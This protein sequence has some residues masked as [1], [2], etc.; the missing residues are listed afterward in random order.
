MRAAIHILVIVS[1]AALF[2]AALSLFV[3]FLPGD[4][5]HDLAALVNKRDALESH[6]APRLIF[7]GGSSL[8]T[9]RSPEIE[10]AVNSKSRPHRSVINLGLWG[11]L[12]I[13]RY[14]DHVFPRLKSGDIVV[15]SQEYATLLDRDYFRYIRT[16]E[17]ARRF[18]LLMSPGPTI[19]GLF[20][21][22]NLL[23]AVSDITMLN[24]MKVKTYLSLI[25]DLNFRHRFTGGY[26]R[27][28][29][30]YNKF[31]DRTRPFSITRPLQSGG[32]RFESPVEG[33]I[34]YL[35]EF[36]K[37]SRLKGIRVFFAFPPFPEP[38][39]RINRDHISALEIILRDDLGLGLLN[40][41]REAVYPE[42]CFADTV[43]HL[44]PACEE[45]RSAALTKRLA[46]RLKEAGGGV[47]FFH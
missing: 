35:K 5:N 21:D 13:E 46:V 12:S 3:W 28:A 2:A 38:D 41:P 27:Y 33:N 14:L 31:G 32:A 23:D 15:I 20:A 7:I 30:Q 37:R 29:R 45:L 39:Y 40:S 22:G 1:L 44:T 19:A 11:G 24:Q 43:N 26:Y 47:R 25:L 42:S 16:N 17:E 6:P 8:A 18:F 36:S 4:Y 9:L 34:R 10:K